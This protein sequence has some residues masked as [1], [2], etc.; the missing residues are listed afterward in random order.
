MT[1]FFSRSYSRDRRS[2]APFREEAV[3]GLAGYAEPTQFAN[4]PELEKYLAAR[5]QLEC[6]SISLQRDFIGA[7]TPQRMGALS[8]CSIDD[9]SQLI[10]LS[11]GYR[12][13]LVTHLVRGDG[14][15]RAEPWPPRSYYRFIARSA[16]DVYASAVSNRIV[17]LMAGPRSDQI[18]SLYCDE[19]GAVAST[20]AE[21]E[22][23]ATLFS[24]VRAPEDDLFPAGVG[25]FV[26][27]LLAQHSAPSSRLGMGGVVFAIG[28]ETRFLHCLLR[29]LAGEGFLLSLG[30]ED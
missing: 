14:A 19:Q 21:A 18:V 17:D 10:E 7:E 11:V 23:I 15:A 4:W 8:V 28:A 22:S 27:A 2:A 29:R 12:A 30:R 24:V 13:R 25:A 20:T 9:R 26:R 5:L 6:V 16:L 3:A 1:P